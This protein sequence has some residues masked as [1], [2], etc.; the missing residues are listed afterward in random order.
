VRCFIN[1][2]DADE[3]PVGTDMLKAAFIVEINNVGRDI[4]HRSITNLQTG[5]YAFSFVPTKIDT[6]KVAVLYNYEGDTVVI[7]KATV[8]VGAGKIDPAMT[9]VTMAE[10]M[11]AGAS[12]SV[13][14]G[15]RDANLNPTGASQN[16]VGFKLV[17]TKGTVKVEGSTPEAT[18]PPYHS[19]LRLTGPPLG[20]WT[21]TVSYAEGSFEETIE[22][23]AGEVSASHSSFQCDA[24]AKGGSMAVCT[25][26]LSDEFTNPVEPTEDRISKIYLYVDGVVADVV[27]GDTQADSGRVNALFRV[28][29]L[30]DSLKVEFVYVA[31][32]DRTKLM[33]TGDEQ[34]TETQVAVSPIEIDAA[35]SKLTCDLTEVSAGSEVICTMEIVKIGEGLIDSTLVNALTAIVYNNGQ[36]PEVTISHE[37]EQWFRLSYTPTAASAVTI[38]DAMLTVSYLCETIGGNGHSVPMSVVADVVAPLKSELS[39]AQVSYYA[40]E[41]FTCELLLKDSFGN[42]L[43]DGNIQTAQVQLTSVDDTISGSIATAV[44]SEFTAAN[45]H[46]F[47]LTLTKAGTHEVEAKFNADVVGATDSVAVQ[48]VA[49]DVDKTTITCPPTAVASN[50]NVVCK[51]RAFDPYDNPTNCRMAAILSNTVVEII[52]FYA[53]AIGNVS[54]VEASC[55]ERQVKAVSGTLGVFDF[56]IKAPALSST[57][58]VRVVYSLG[59]GAS[60]DLEKPNDIIVTPIPVNTADSTLV[61]DESPT[62]GVVM[63]CSLTVT[64]DNVAIGDAD[65]RPLSL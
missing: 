59:D 25:V 60:V 46:V 43:V 1:T 2:V 36:N 6:A 63:R 39:C 29:I 62:A 8:L 55:L 34:E 18:E 24:E 52:P 44:W 23:H 27:W 56:V 10:R 9:V 41:P 48:P 17:A 58:A 14:F 65:L 7:G 11:A 47:E 3:A 33:V 51:I 30:E 49:V 37:N 22:L 53:V 32:G 5:V 42:V 28:G 31:D 57:I 20:E 4:E 35:A 12:V 45:T 15:P 26:S 61:C 64:N 54:N 16:A 19:T 21:V 13:A 38:R 40:G 50:P